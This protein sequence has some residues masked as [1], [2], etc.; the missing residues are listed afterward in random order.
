MDTT[1]IGGNNGVEE[2]N[3]V[4]Q[5]ETEKGERNKRDEQTVQPPSEVLKSLSPLINSIRPFGLYFTR[6]SRVG[7][8]TAGQLN[9]QGIRGCRG[10]NL[11]RIYAT[12]M[13][14]LIWFN[15]LRHC[16]VFDG[17]ESLGAH[18]F[19]ELGNIAGSLLI[20]TLHTTYYIASHTGSLERVFHQ[21]SLPASDI[22]SKYSRKTE[23]VTVVCWLLTAT[24]ITYYAY[25]VFSREQPIN[26]FSLAFIIKTFRMSK[27]GVYIAKVVG[28]ML[29]LHALASLVF[30]Q[31]MNIQNRT[32]SR[33]LRTLFDPTLSLFWSLSNFPLRAIKSRKVYR[34]FVLSNHVV[35]SC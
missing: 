24:N 22:S 3:V 8:A 20:G 4:I 9:R 14:V 18:L 32:V 19:S 26:D 33:L 31:A 6:T 11:A 1:R 21:T 15:S 23:V 7:P 27:P 2:R 17:N 5:M 35:R 28:I 34:V 12:V 10:W 16:V 29:Q 25:T 13:L 30:S